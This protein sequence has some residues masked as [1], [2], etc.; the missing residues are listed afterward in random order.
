[1]A[2]NVKVDVNNIPKILS[3]IDELNSKNL[4]VGLFAPEGSDLFIIGMANEYG[5]HIPVSNKMRAY[6]H[7]QGVHLKKTT[8]EIEIPERS[9][10][11]AGFENS[12]E[13]IAEYITRALPLAI[14]GRLEV[15]RFYS[16]LGEV[17]VSKITDYMQ[18]LRTP[19]NSDLTIAR[20]GSSNPLIDTGRLIQSITYRVVNV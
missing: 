2:F 16:L 17:C 11:R 14:D 8:T 20:K 18:Q 7:Y 4:E 1:M 13:F 15:D 9:Y 5:A 10:I 6:M 19:P 3:N 12:K